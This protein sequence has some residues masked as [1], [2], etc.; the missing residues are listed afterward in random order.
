MKTTQ[1]QRAWDENERPE[2]RDNL[3]WPLATFLQGSCCR[4]GQLPVYKHIVS[5]LIGICT[6]LKA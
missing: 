4:L 2:G 5:T 1:S 6:S 3:R